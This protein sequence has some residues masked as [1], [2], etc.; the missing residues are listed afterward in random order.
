MPRDEVT[1]T[2]EGYWQILRYAIWAIRLCGFFGW[3]CG[4]FALKFTSL[5]WLG[6]RSF[7]T[8]HLRY[9]LRSSKL[10]I[11]LQK[12]RSCPDD[13]TAVAAACCHRP[14]NIPDGTRA[15]S[16]IMKSSIRPWLVPIICH[17]LLADSRFLATFAC[18]VCAWVTDAV[19]GMRCGLWA[20]LI[21]RWL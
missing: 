11:H 17:D 8:P 4:S 3:L 13:W 2:P 6:Q 14:M 15:A 7:V 10:K 20:L 16:H 19:Q 12:C 9:L 21:H 5:E 18:V 1:G